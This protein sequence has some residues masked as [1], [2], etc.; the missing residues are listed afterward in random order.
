MKFKKLFQ[1]LTLTVFLLLLTSFIA[2]KTGKLDKYL[3]SGDN[4]KEQQIASQNLPIDS[5]KV[6]KRDTVRQN[7]AMMSTSK[8]MV[9]IDQ[10]VKFEVDTTKKKSKK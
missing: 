2:Y 8:S 10:K 3:I 6:K 9:I 5:P 7:P 1:G 4:S